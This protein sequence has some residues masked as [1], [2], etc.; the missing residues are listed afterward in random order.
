MK[1]LVTVLAGCF[2]TFC[3]SAQDDN[4]FISKWNEGY[5]VESKDGAFKM[6]FGGRI[7]YDLA[8]F[9]Q[10][11]RITEE[12][13]EL[14]SGSE[15]RRLRLFNAGEI[16][17][18]VTYK[19]QLD[20][21]GGKVAFKSVFIQFN[22]IPVLGQL[23]VGHFKEPFRLEALT[24]SKYITLMERSF[25]MPFSPDRNAGAMI[26]N[27]TP[28]QRF[29]WQL[30]IFRNANSFGDDNSGSDHNLTARIA[31]LV[32]KND[33]KKQLIHLGIGYS[34]RSPENS[35]YNINSMPSAHLAPRYVSTGT[36]EDVNGVD[37]FNAEV[38]GVFGPFSIQSE[39]L[40]A[41]V[42]T[43]SSMSFSAFYTQASYFL[44]GEHREYKSLLGGFDKVKP[45]NNAGKEGKG[46][47]EITARYST[48][49]LDDGIITGGTMNELALGINWYLNPATRIMLNYV[50]VDLKNVGIS[51]ILQMRFQ[52]EF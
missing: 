1:K 50:L 8:F 12:F 48:I 30:G 29:G 19:V 17:D 52:V 24:S 46:A 27:E 10:D 11:S 42:K 36:I 18:N 22:K 9:D 41:S 3:I 6:K 34:N 49:D 51:N 31:G 28:D 25:N 4:G 32:I 45:R 44:S 43:V 14:K 15:F 38:A 35:E 21:A 37:L 26:F 33:D 16:Y 13:G 2:L 5:K 39:F 23:R 47:W 40:T 7:M 20:F